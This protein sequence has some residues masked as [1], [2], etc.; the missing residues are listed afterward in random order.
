MIAIKSAKSKSINPLAR[1]VTPEAIA[2]LL[3]INVSDIKEIRCW[4]HVILVVAK[5]LTRFVSYADLPPIVGVE[6]PTNKDFLTWRKRWQKTKTYQAPSFWVQ[7]YAAKL[8]QSGSFNQLYTWG[9]LLSLIT[10]ALSITSLEA[11][12]KVFREVWEVIN[13][14]LIPQT[15]AAMNM[16]S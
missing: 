10:F 1:F 16:Y 15:P 6:P 7:F 14:K 4:A 3:K 2:L 8:R 11:L 13:E 9:R 5:H 12:R